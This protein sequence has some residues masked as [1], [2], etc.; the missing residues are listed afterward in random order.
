MGVM[1]PA[2]SSDRFIPQEDL[3]LISLRGW[4]NPSVILRLEGL[5]KLKKFSDLMGTR[6]RDLPACS[7]HLNHL[8]YSVPPELLVSEVFKL[9]TNFMQLN[10]TREAPSC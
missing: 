2:L 3:V 5:G 1:F 6:N 4:V 10:T 7:E 8:S 9:L